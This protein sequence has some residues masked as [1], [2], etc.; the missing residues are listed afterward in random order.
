[1]WGYTGILYWVD[2]MTLFFQSAECDD[3]LSGYLL[4]VTVSVQLPGNFTDSPG[5]QPQ[6]KASLSEIICITDVLIN[7]LT[8]FYYISFV[9]VHFLLCIYSIKALYSTYKGVL[10]SP[11]IFTGRKSFWTCCHWRGTTFLWGPS[12]LEVPLKGSSHPDRLM[13]SLI[14]S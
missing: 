14:L 12:S 13:R 1:M 9:H 6:L 5:I 10:L 8:K 2:S 3:L 4:V 11:L 7:V